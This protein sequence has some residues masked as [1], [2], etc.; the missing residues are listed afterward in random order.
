LLKPLATAVAHDVFPD[1]HRWSE[2]LPRVEASLNKGGTVCFLSTD[3]RHEKMG[4]ETDARR[5][6]REGRAA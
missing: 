2:V 1:A 6:A 5:E 3:R 4:T